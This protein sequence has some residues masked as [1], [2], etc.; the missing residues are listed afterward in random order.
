MNILKIVCAVLLT[1]GFASGAVAGKPAGQGTVPPYTVYG[2]SDDCTGNCN[3]QCVKV[4]CDEGYI[5]IGGGATLGDDGPPGNTNAGDNVALQVNMP[6]EY[7]GL[8]GW[9]A[10]GRE[11]QNRPGSGGF[12]T[13]NPDSSPP[14]CQGTPA[15]WCFENWQHGTPGSVNATS[16]PWTVTAFAICQFV[17]NGQTVPEFR[18]YFFD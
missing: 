17:P 8:Y 3:F 12:G 13:G 16:Y 5:V 14:E 18:D 11:L 1:V 7:N 2:E 15:S 9:A 6:F 4:F 10:C